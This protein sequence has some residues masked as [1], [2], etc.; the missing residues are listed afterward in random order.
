M[1]LRRGYLSRDLNG[2]K[3]EILQG[4]VVLAGQHT[5]WG[6]NTLDVF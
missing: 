2:R 6:R 4:K 1:P 5:P 3:A